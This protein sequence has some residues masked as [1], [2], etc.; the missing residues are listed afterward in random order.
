MWEGKT[1]MDVRKRLEIIDE[2]VYN[3]KKGGEQVC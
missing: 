2:E 1:K 3:L